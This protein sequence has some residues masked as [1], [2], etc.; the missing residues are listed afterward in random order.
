MS[1]VLASVFP[2]K[3]VSLAILGLL[4]LAWLWK[5]KIPR[6][7]SGWVSAVVMLLGGLIILVYPTGAFACNVCNVAYWAPAIALPCI[8]FF[9]VLLI[10]QL[11]SRIN[12]KLK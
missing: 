1:D 3:V 11:L 10:I 4:L 2:Y 6:R 5:T 9:A 7:V 12:S 8:L